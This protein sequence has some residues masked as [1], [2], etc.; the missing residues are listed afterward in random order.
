MKKEATYWEL[1]DKC[2]GRALGKLKTFGFRVFICNKE[3]RDKDYRWAYFCDVDDVLGYIQQ[4][5]LGIG[6]N[7][8]TIHK[9]TNG[10]GSGLSCEYKG[11]K[12]EDIYDFDREEA[13]VA[14]SYDGG[15]L[16]REDLVLVR[17]VTVEECKDIING[18]LVEI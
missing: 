14:F 3:I 15:W 11:K 7:F 13:E 6:I 10:I 17:K 2:F 8:G 4:S 9:P 12:L 5:D 1:K 16:K 18:R